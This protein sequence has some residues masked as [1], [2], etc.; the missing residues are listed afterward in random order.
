MLEARERVGGRVWSSTLTNGAVIELGAEWIMAD[1]IA[2]REAAT[3][4][5]V[6]LMETGA[7]YGHRE[8]WGPGAA[9]LD[10]QAA[11]LDAARVARAGV[12]RGSG[13]GHSAWASSSIRCRA[14]RRHVA[15]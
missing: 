4:F 10:D 7:Y 3:R 6:E 5:E 13:R 14:R 9:S 11:F 12:A 2:V 8:P 1:D 15:W